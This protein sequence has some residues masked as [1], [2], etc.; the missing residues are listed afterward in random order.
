M[1]GSIIHHDYRPWTW[2]WIAMWQGFLFNECGI[3]VAIDTSL[4]HVAF[5]ISID[6]HRWEYTEVSMPFECD[7]LRDNLSLS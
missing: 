3:S 1:Y 6:R 4:I 7:L 2:K 5:E